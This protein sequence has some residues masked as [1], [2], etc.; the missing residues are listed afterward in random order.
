MYYLFNIYKKYLHTIASINILK[1]KQIVT[2]S[3]SQ[4]RSFNSDKLFNKVIGIYSKL[5]NNDAKIF[6]T[7]K[8]ILI[9]LIIPTLNRE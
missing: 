2:I 3:I 8:T 5:K 6:H 4:G 7:L 1:T 9:S